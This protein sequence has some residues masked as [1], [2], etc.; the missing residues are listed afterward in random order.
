M[1][2]KRKF[3]RFPV[4][5]DAQYL[6]EPNQ[7]EWKTCKVVN[8]GRAGM[9]IEV[10]LQ[11]RLQTGSILKI[12]V[13][14]PPRDEPVKAIGILRWVK[15]LMEEKCFLGGVKFTEIDPE[16]TWTLLDYAYNKWLGKQK[17]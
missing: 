10:H 6:L 5:L 15:E 12:E 11:E 7:K 8:V 14:V 9:G 17:T 4:E 13:L 1:K 3:K 2:D 16:D